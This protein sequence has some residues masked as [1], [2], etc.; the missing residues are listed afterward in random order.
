[1]K[2]SDLKPGMII[3]NHLGNPFI[4]MAEPNGN[5]G[6]IGRD[7]Y[8]SGFTNIPENL[9]DQG[10]DDFKKSGLSRITLVG[11]P[12]KLH[13]LSLFRDYYN[14]FDKDKD[15]TFL[16]HID[17]IWADSALSKH[18]ENI[19]TKAENLNETSKEIKEIIDFIKDLQ[20]VLE[21]YK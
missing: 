7:I 3:F 18:L 15:P 1:M 8:Y 17:I 6:A 20:K 16:N 21:S 2:K 5:I 10:T 4:V 9:E 19:Q 11:Y 12:K 13:S 14:R